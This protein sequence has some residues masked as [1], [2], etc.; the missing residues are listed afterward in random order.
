MDMYQLT[1]VKAIECTFDEDANICGWRQS[2]SGTF[3]GSIW[4]RMDKVHTMPVGAYSG[5]YFM[6]LAA[7]SAGLRLGVGDD[8]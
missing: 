6:H 3:S 1:C 8:T 5:S 2:F 4:Q 7:F